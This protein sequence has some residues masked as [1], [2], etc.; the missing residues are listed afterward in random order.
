MILDFRLVV[1]SYV[2]RCVSWPPLSQ[3]QKRWLQ[4]TVTEGELVKS[5]FSASKAA[6]FKLLRAGLLGQKKDF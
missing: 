1:T 4:F 2:S 6:A 3:K 5:A